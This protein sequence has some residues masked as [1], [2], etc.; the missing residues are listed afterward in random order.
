M[1]ILF[2]LI[3]YNQGVGEGDERGLGENLGWGGEGGWE[4]VGRKVGREYWSKDQCTI[5]IYYFCTSIFF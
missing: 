4:G 3:H 2:M 1:P 5:Y